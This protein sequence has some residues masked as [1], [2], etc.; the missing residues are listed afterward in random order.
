MTQDLVKAKLN[1]SVAIKSLDDLVR[2]REAENP[3]LLVDVSGSMSERMRNGKTKIE[4]L[5]QVVS[6][7][8]R[9][10][11]ATL[12]AFGGRDGGAYVVNSVPQAGGG[13][14]LAEAIDLARTKEAGRCVVIS[15]GM[16]DSQNAAM[17]AARA[18]G[19]Q[20][21]VV[22]VGDPSDDSIYGGSAFLKRLAESTGGSEFNGDLSKPLELAGKV[23]GLLA[24]NVDD[25]EEGG[26][27]LL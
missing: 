12:I 4:A 20:I 11:R 27:I 8:T 19:G 16:P 1:Q 25:D 14:P 10:Q 18:F 21:D 2:V 22:Y 13:T 15:D 9:S 3:F 17:D 23:A 7:A 26:A 6:D 24:G 5:R